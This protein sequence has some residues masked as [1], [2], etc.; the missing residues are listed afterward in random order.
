MKRK[1]T[2]IVLLIYLALFLAFI[3]WKMHQN[4]QDTYGPGDFPEPN[5]EVQMAEKSTQ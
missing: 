2:V 4:Q 1:V 3:G 5:R